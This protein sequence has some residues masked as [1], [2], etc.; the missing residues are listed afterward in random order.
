MGLLYRG[1]VWGDAHRVKY[2]D[3]RRSEFG[4]RPYVLTPNPT[5]IRKRI[6]GKKGSGPLH[7]ER[8]IHT[9]DKQLRRAAL[10]VFNQASRAARLIVL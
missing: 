7:N 2:A 5:G 4:I 3:L 9:H 1:L 8:V 6:A 10:M